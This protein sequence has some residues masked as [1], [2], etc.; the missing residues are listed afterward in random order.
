MALVTIF[1]VMAFIM[2]T[3]VVIMKV[4]IMALI[5]TCVLRTLRSEPA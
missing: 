5:A 1:N 3:K 2:T 4:L